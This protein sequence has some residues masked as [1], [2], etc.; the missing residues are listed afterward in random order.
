MIDNV[1]LGINMAGGIGAI[2]P[3][4]A[5][6]PN[7]RPPAVMTSGGTLDV[8]YG[9]DISTAGSVVGGVGVGSRTFIVG[10]T[11]ADAMTPPAFGD[12]DFARTTDGNFL[13]TAVPGPFSLALP[14]DDATLNVMNVTPGGGLACD[15]DADGDCD[16]AD[17]D[18]L[19]VGSPTPAD[20][21]TWLADASA[22]SNPYKAD[23]ADTY[24]VGDANLD[25]D[26]DSADL[27]LLLNNFSS[28]AGVGWGGG[29][30]NADSNVNS[31]DLGLLLNNFSFSSS[32]AAAVPEPT[33]I[34]YGVVF[35]VFCLVRRRA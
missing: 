12:D 19:Y 28:T 21:S 24:V 25:G 4:A 31:S 9:Q 30:L 18:L 15:L 23:P 8:I 35:V 14:W 17:I 7:E 32:S 16:H 5:G 26:V 6:M 13:D 3:I 29:D 11:F 22:P 20:I 33:G 27:G 1:N 2:D 10:G 34:P